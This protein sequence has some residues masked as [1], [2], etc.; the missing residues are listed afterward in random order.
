MWPYDM[1]HM[2]LSTLEKEE[3]H[4]REFCIFVSGLTLVAIAMLSTYGEVLH[5]A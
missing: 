1:L 2:A 3:R 5:I 4:N